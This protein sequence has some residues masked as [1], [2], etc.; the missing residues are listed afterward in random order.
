MIL[1]KQRFFLT[2]VTLCVMA[3]VAHGQA[4]YPNKPLRIIV[5]F[6]SG[7]GVDI[8]GRL[9]AQKIGP[10]LGQT[11][12]VENRAGAGGSIGADL[13][14]KSAPDGYTLL[15]GASSTM[16]V[17]PNVYEKLPYDTSRDFVAVTMLASAP[18]VLAVHPSVPAKTVRELIEL[19]K[20]SPGTL[21]F[22]SGGNGS[23]GHLSGEML[24]VMAGVNIVHVPYKGSAPAVTDLVAGQV[25]MIFDS[26]LSVMPHVK[27]GRARALGVGSSERSSIAPEVPTIAESGELPGYRAVIWYGAFV[28]AATPAAIVARLNT[29]IVKA[30]RQPDSRESMARQG[31]DIMTGSS[32]DATS[33]ARAELVRWGKVIKAA[34]IKIQ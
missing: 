29:E 2:L 31:A 6:P 32:E 16:A 12:I 17:N 23:G 15:I 25:Q 20:R 1:I 5:P 27:A 10:A 26:P 18:I 9:V 11:V 21:N 14:A 30:L 4:S 24:K 7:G 8:I 19:A 33:F 22:A 28:P 3:G 13:V 34:G